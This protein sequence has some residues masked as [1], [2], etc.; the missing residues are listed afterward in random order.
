MAK[1]AR[2]TAAKFPRRAAVGTGIPKRISS[3]TSRASMNSMASTYHRP[4]MAT[5]QRRMKL[6]RPTMAMQMMLATIR[7]RRPR[8]KL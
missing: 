3:D 4:F 7:N 8:V 1:K 6:P 2:P 5:R